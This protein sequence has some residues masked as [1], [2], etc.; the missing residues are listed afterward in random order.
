MIRFGLSI[1]RMAFAGYSCRPVAAFSRYSP[2]RPND[3]PNTR[4]DQYFGYGQLQVP[5]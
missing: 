3:H 1:R 2:E 5:H 4:K